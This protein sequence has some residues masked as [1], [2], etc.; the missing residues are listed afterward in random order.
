M[1]SHD[2][3]S[4]LV[5]SRAPNR[6]RRATADF[7]SVWQLVLSPW[8]FVLGPFV[9]LG[10]CLVLSPSVVLEAVGTGWTK[11]CTLDRFLRKIPRQRRR[12]RASRRR[13][14]RHHD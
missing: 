5:L 12:A 13:H 7:D 11:P 3:E 8:C 2:V 14:P 9:V 1:N 4:L 6:F 10:P